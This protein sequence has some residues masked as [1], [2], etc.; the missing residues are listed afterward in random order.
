MSSDRTEERRMRLHWRL[1]EATLPGHSPT[2]SCSGGNGRRRNERSEL[3]T[4]ATNVIPEGP[5]GRQLRPHRGRQ[6]TAGRRCPSCDLQGLLCGRVDFVVDSMLCVR[7]G[8]H[9]HAVRCSLTTF[10]DS[11]TT[12]HEQQNHETS[13]E[14]DAGSID[15]IRAQ[16]HSDEGRSNPQ[17]DDVSRD[18]L[19]HRR[20][21]AH[22]TM[23]LSD[24]YKILANKVS[25]TSF[26]CANSK[27][28]STRPIF[29]LGMGSYVL[30][31]APCLARDCWLPPLPALVCRWAVGPVGG[32]A[33]ASGICECLKTAPS[34]LRNLAVT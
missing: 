4:V 34:G 28:G 10:G 8:R 5:F 3:N 18:L 14:D 29:S 13:H 19:E 27:L 2:A 21:V 30:S 11:P 9:T 15:T 1:T 31:Q 25:T 22:N 7:I 6:G 17:F 20:K 32:L 33:G 12:R 24:D 16:R 23:R 26:A